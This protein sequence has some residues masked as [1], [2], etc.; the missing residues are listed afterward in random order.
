MGLIILKLQNEILGPRQESTAC[1]M[2]LV[3]IDRT[4]LHLKSR[5]YLLNHH[6]GFNC[7]LIMKNSA[8]FL[9][10]SDS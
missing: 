5:A 4:Q 6:F 1:F 2:R 7:D 10:S 8:K 9:L 3:N